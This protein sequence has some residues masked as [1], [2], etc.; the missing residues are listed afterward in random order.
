MTLPAFPFLVP[1]DVRVSNSE[2]KEIKEQ[3]AKEKNTWDLSERG[4]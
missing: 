1:S 3:G 4:I 2:E